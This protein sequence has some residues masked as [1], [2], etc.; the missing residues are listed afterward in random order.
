[1]EGRYDE[2]RIDGRCHRPRVEQRRHQPSAPQL[3]L[4]RGV[5]RHAA[6]RARPDDR[7]HRA[8]DRRRRSRWS[9][10]PVLG[11]DE[12]SAGVD[13]R[14]R[15]RGQ[16]RR[17]LRPQSGLP[18]VGGVLP[19]R[20]GAVRHERVDDHAGGVPRAAGHRRR[21][22]HGDGDGRHRR[23]HPAARARS[24]SGRARRGIRRHHG[25]RP[26]AR[27]I[28][29]RPPHLAVGVLDQ[30]PR[31]GRRAARRRRGHP[32]TGKGDPTR[33]R[34]RG[35]PHSRPRRLGAHAGHQ[36]GW[37]RIRMGIPGDHRPV[38]GI[39]R[40]PRGIR[41]GGIPCGRADSADSTVRQPGVHRLLH[42][43][44]H[45]RLRHARRADLPADV[46]A[47]RRRRLRHRRRACAPCRWWR[48][49]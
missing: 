11:R 28:L 25:H 20:I 31:R 46:H 16:A 38:R 18:G 32:V 12:L 4:R 43:R 48:A 15:D 33:H 6:G 41:L 30:H 40:R 45:R 2:S 42:P 26:P 9:G 47:V 19:R 27:R 34:L 10:P 49:C 13:H 14:H 29:H 36:L 8:A 23:G 39:G 44:L 1:M 17:P 5:A 24:L 21:R 3:H 7:G 37:R 22:D 35:H